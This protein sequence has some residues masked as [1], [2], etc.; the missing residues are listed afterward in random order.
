MHEAA[1]AVWEVMERLLDEGAVSAGVHVQGDPEH[2]AVL[3]G[4]HQESIQVLPAGGHCS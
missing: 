1:V 4:P 3:V 2:E